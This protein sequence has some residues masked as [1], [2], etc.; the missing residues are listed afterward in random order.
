MS[1]SLSISFP[2][3][4]AYRTNVFK[5]RVAFLNSTSQFFMNCELIHPPYLKDGRSMSLCGSVS[6]FLS[7]S[8]VYSHVTLAWFNIR[9]SSD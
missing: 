8:T 9:S 7:K 1:L 6:D 3:R 2:A 4:I 5:L